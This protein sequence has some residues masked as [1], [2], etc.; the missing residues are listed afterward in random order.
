M[1]LNLGTKFCVTRVLLY[2]LV[3]II[4]IYIFIEYI[5]FRSSLLNSVDL[6]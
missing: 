2:L 5:L 6:A 4:V 1:N 3:L